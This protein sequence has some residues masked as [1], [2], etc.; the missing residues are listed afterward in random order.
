[1]TSRKKPDYRNGCPASG[2]IA[3]CLS[4]FCPALS[5]EGGGAFHAQW[6]LA[7]PLKLVVSHVTFLID[8]SLAVSCR[9]V[10]RCMALRTTPELC[11]MCLLSDQARRPSA[12]G[13]DAGRL[14]PS[15]LLDPDGWMPRELC[16]R[17][18]EEVVRVTGDRFAGAHVTES[19]RLEGLGTWG[20]TVASWRRSV[21]YTRSL[22]WRTPPMW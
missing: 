19:V 14:A 13:F 8:L 1:M 6:G 17:L 20:K 22:S 2:A 4:C 10:F 15:A 18:G 3:R 5:L 12:R 7:D 16:F 11:F 9:K 21:S